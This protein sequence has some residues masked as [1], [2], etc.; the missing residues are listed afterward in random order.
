MNVYNSFTIHS[1]NYVLFVG[2]F[3]VFKVCPECVLI[4]LVL[5]NS[6]MI[7]NCP[8]I[9]VQIK[10]TTMKLYQQLPEA[11]EKQWITIYDEN[12]T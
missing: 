12:S 11:T 4:L 10:S 6:K 8:I 2:Q 7:L 3:F 5:L 1:V 9:N